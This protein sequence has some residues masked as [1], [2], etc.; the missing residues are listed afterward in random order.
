MW[1][2]MMRKRNCSEWRTLKKPVGK[3]AYFTNVFTN[4]AGTN[5]RK[6][7]TIWEN[8]LETHSFGIVQKPCKIKRLR[9]NTEHLRSY[10]I[11]IKILF[12]CHGSTAGSRELAA[13]V[14]QNGANRGSW[15]SG[16]LRFYYEWGNEKRAYIFK[17]FFRDLRLRFYLSWDSSFASVGRHFPKNMALQSEN[18]SR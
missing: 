11:M 7:E 10:G 17:P 15:E 6:Y 4:F 16:L 18:P 2:S 3:A 8:T 5:M 13:F 14:G 12:I 1:I 9:R